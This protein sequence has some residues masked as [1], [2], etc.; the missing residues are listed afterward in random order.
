MPGFEHRF[1][2]VAHFKAKPEVG[3]SSTVVYGADSDEGTRAYVSSEYYSAD[4]EAPE[5]AGT[6]VV[7]RHESGIEIVHA[8]IPEQ[9]ERN[10]TSRERAMVLLTFA[11]LA[12]DPRDGNWK[13]E[14]R[15]FIDPENEGVVD[16]AYI[17]FLGIHRKRKVRR[18]G[19]G[20]M[21]SEETH[22]LKPVHRIAGD[23]HSGLRRMQVSRDPSP[24]P[25]DHHN[26]AVWLEAERDIA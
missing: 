4:Q 26:A 3:G 19:P 1:E 5:H 23:A 21:Q 8:N 7:A 12:D 13:V 9:A 16:P 20:G 11:M 14:E 18:L 17:A 2:P 24:I 10:L 22:Y 6:L 25:Q 15:V